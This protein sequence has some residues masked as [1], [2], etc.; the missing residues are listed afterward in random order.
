MTKSVCIEEFCG[1]WVASKGLCPRHHGL[2]VGTDGSVCSVPDCPRGEYGRKGWCKKHYNSA[3][4]QG[5]T[6]SGLR[7]QEPGCEAVATSKGKCD[8]HR[9]AE[10]RRKP[11]SQCE[12][13]SCKLLAE[14]RG[15]C[16]GHYKQKARGEDLTRLK[17]FPRPRGQWG[18]WYVSGG[19]Y[20]ERHRMTEDGVREYQK[21]HRHVM[22]VALGRKLFHGENVHHLNGIRDDNR[23]ENLERWSTSQPAGQRVED[24]TAWAIEWLEQYAPERL[25]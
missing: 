11:E 10:R 17:S 19:G 6:G 13:D 16:Q 14:S 2:S 9:R 12:F 7:C 1:G 25:A 15:L 24:K 5:L 21:Q 3:R 20:V 18:D 8:P 23:L 22:E 4:K